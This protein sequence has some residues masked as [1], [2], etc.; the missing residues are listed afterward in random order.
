MI[1]RCWRAELFG[2]TCCASYRKRYGGGRDAVAGD[3][4]RRCYKIDSALLCHALRFADDMRY[5]PWRR[6]RRRY[7]RSAAMALALAADAAPCCCCLL[8]LAAISWRYALLAAPMHSATRQRYA[9]AADMPPLLLAFSMLFSMSAGH[10]LPWHGML[11]A[12]KAFQQQAMLIRLAACAQAAAP[13]QALRNAVDALAAAAKIK[14]A[15]DS[16]LMALMI[17]VGHTCCY[18]DMTCRASRH[19]MF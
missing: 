15:G 2:D 7:V 11:A 14:A 13:R 3:T 4:L 18:Y 5:M 10:A 9:Y 19:I 17:C 6:K 12:A 1:W 16:A 8:L